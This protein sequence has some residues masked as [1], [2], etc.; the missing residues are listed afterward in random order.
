[1]RL[2]QYVHTTVSLSPHSLIKKAVSQVLLK[3]GLRR[4]SQCDNKSSTYQGFHPSHLK[5]YFS[6]VPIDLLLLHAG[7]I[8]ALADRYLLHC[9]NLLGSGWVQV[10][11]GMSCPGLQG[12]RFEM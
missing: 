9:F 3:L 11:H 4:I 2:R 8:E 5:S 1:M 12:Y 10:I 7:E 6:A